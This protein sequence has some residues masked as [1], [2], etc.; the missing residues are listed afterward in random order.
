MV[1]LV[2]NPGIEPVMLNDRFWRIAAILGEGRL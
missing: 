2:R 1:C